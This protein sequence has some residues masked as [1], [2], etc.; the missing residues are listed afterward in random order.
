MIP[1]DFRRKF[2]PLLRGEGI[3]FATSLVAGLLKC[4]G[5]EALDW[6]PLTI[7]MELQSD[8]DVEI[9]SKTF[10]KISALVNAITT[11][12]VYEDVAVF[13]ETISALAGFGLNTQRDIPSVIDTAWA[14]AE[15]RLCDPVPVGRNPNNPWSSN[16]RKY[17]RVVLNDEGL[18]IPPE[19]LGFAP[20]TNVPDVRS[21]V[22]S[23]NDALQNAQLMAAE[24]DKKIEDIAI[25]MLGQL[26]Y[27]GL[28]PVTAPEKTPVSE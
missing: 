9:N 3:A 15:I 14:V 8:F 1:A 21:S 5:T 13:D 18:T 17:V 27:L 6:D 19:I 11:E 20:L 10:D 23:Y 7:Q 25:T 4:Y 26:Q 16:I 22:S 28:A 12:T 2:S 24:V